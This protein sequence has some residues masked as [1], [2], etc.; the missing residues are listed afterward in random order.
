MGNCCVDRELSK[1]SDI[2]VKL[3]QGGIIS[4]DVPKMIEYASKY[5]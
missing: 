5:L 2:N 4:S 1:D 3:N